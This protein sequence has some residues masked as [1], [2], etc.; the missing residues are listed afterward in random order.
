MSARDEISIDQE[1]RTRSRACK[2]NDVF[3]REIGIWNSRRHTVWGELESRS[4]ASKGRSSF[5]LIAYDVCIY[6]RDKGEKP[7]LAV[8]DH[9]D[10]GRGVEMIP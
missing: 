7:Q 6:R 5:T 8:C 9:A 4:R 3:V 1:T 2:S 10:R